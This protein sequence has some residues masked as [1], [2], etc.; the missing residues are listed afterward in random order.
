MPSSP[1]AAI[2]KRQEIA[3]ASRMM[4]GWVAGAS[5]VV[6]IAAVL[7]ITLFQKLTF[8]QDIIAKQNK[9]ISILESNQSAATELLDN[10]RALD[11]NESLRDSRAN[12]D[13]DTALQ[14]ILEALP[15]TANNAALGSSLQDRLLKLNG[16]SIESLIVGG[17]A[18]STTFSSN[19]SIPLQFSFVAKATDPNKLFDLLRQL[20]KS[21]RPIKILT[22]SFET[23]QLDTTL[24]VSAESYYQPPV[25]LD[26]GEETLPKKRGR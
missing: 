14:V 2:R 13:D 7:S 6:G 23:G 15:S 12:P 19:G 20:E 9:T 1:N 17:T 16:V 25:S 18:E 26:L 5:A 10:A 3:K 11:T 8:N 21:I 22:L 4:F 24:T